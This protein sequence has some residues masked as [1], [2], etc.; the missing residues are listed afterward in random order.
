MTTTYIP[1]LIRSTVY[2]TGILQ[3]VHVLLVV[4]VIVYLIRLTYKT[5]KAKC[6]SVLNKTIL[7]ADKVFLKRSVIFCCIKG[8]P[9]KPLAT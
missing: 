3:R 2:Y 8:G 1:L 5:Y 4:K 7:E 9:I 6:E